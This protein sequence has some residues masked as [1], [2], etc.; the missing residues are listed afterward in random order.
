MNVL[1]SLNPTAIQ[2]R[3]FWRAN[4]R[5]CSTLSSCLNRNFSSSTDRMRIWWQYEIP[6]AYL[7]AGSPMVRRRRLVTIFGAKRWI[8]RRLTARLDSLCENE[9]DH[10]SQMHAIAARP[11]P[12]VQEPGFALFVSIQDFIEIP[13]SHLESQHFIRIESKFDTHRCEKNIP[14]LRKICGLCPVTFSNLS[15][16]AVSTLRVPNCTMSLS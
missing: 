11:S 9:R 8:T 5:V 16:N 1:S 10:M 7:W 14:L 2:S 12:G 6:S 4:A 15:N 3:A 13:S